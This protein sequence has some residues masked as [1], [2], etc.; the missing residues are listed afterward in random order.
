MIVRKLEALFTLNVNRS[1]FNEA[2]SGLKSLEEKAQA[3]MGAVAGY[4]AVGAFHDFVSSV[5]QI[6]KTAAHLGVTTD[7]LQELRYA[8]EKSGLTIDGLEEALKE[9]QIRSVDAAS[10]EGDAAEGFQKLGL[11]STD[12]AGRIREPLELLDAVSERLSS[13]PSQAERLW[14]GDALFGDEGAKIISML[15]KGSV[16]LKTMREEARRMGRVLGGETIV[17]A[18]R[19]TRSMHRL[20]DASVNSAL[21]MSTPAF[22]PIA[23]TIDGISTMMER[24]SSKT[25]SP[26]TSG[27]VKT[28]FLGTLAL[29]AAKATQAL[30]PLTP[31][32][33]A[34][35]TVFGKL[36]LRGSGIGL[37]LLLLQDIWS[38][39][40]G[41]ESVTGLLAQSLEKSLKRCGEFLNRFCG[42]AKVALKKGFQDAFA[43]VEKEFDNLSSWFSDSLARFCK[44]TQ[45]VIAAIM[46]DFLHDG[47]T[48]LIGKSPRRMSAHDVARFQD[49]RNVLSTSIDQQRTIKNTNHVNIAVNVAA[50]SNPRETGTDVAKAIKEAFERERF[51]TFMGVMHYAG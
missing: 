3:V 18:D 47:F 22:G 36:A 25:V 14:I 35:L 6:G 26:A 43:S 33:T 2:F 39:F 9:L 48:A 19:L 30:L 20:K 21:H 1:Q 29:V 12:A 17:E 11:K 8:A 41:A 50:S 40:T 34:A 28:G 4:W 5:S 15:K 13:L 32:I 24:L 51:N 10:G 45:E 23:T 49:G 46:P 27:M 7:A 44:K 37:V 16:G 42:E 31:A 38:M